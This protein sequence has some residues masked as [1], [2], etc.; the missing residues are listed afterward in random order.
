MGFEKYVPKATPSKSMP[1]VTIRK[2]GLISFD[3]ASVKEFGLEK[4]SH[5]VLFFDKSKKILAV[6]VCNDGNV[7]GAIKM[8]RRRRT[9]SVKVPQFFESWG[10]ILD[11]V[12]KFNVSF[13]ES[14]GKLI[15]NLSSI[16]RRRGRRAKK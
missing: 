15:V 8:S 11:D 1:Q 9:A 14:E 13:D 7:Q 12:Q 5:L 16:K 3:A 10:L 6:Q 4:A 2:T